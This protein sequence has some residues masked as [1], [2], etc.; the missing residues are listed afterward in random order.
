MKTTVF[1]ERPQEPGDVITGR[2]GDTGYVPLSYTKLDAK[3]RCLRVDCNNKVTGRK[4]YCSKQCS[5]LTRNRHYYETPDGRWKKRAAALRHFQCHRFELYDKRRARMERYIQDLLVSEDPDEFDYD[6]E[7]TTPDAAA[8]TR[9]QRCAR[10]STAGAC[11]ARL[12][13]N[14]TGRY[15]PWS[16]TMGKSPPGIPCRLPTATALLEVRDMKKR[17]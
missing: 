12:A 3:G 5:A 4:K 9:Y 17:A 11:P 10:C 8:M 14:P 15:S 16:A 13:P 6:T 2:L 7:M 1:A